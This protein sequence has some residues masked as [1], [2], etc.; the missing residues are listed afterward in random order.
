MC[1]QVNSCSFKKNEKELVKSWPIQL[2]KRSENMYLGCWVFNWPKI[3]YWTNESVFDHMA[4]WRKLH[5]A[6]S[7]KHGLKY[8]HILSLAW[9]LW[10]VWSQDAVLTLDQAFIL[11]FWI[12]LLWIRSQQ[13][14][15]KLCC[16]FEAWLPNYGLLLVKA[17][18]VL[19]L[20]LFSV[21]C[22]FHPKGGKHYGWSFISAENSK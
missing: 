16:R 17:A 3:F 6:W 18:L 9:C 4:S 2:E 13:K 7:L 1:F 15:Y 22:F 19:F 20:F 12:Q 21:I 14:A 10:N 5:L 11:D 8:P